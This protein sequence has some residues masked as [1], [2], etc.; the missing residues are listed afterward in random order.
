MLV[1]EGKGQ[2]L[3]PLEHVPAHIRLHPDAY[4]MAVILDK[5]VEA[6]F[7]KVNEKQNDAPDDKEPQ[8]AVGDVIVHHIFGD[9]GVK[10]IAHRHNERADHI[11]GKKPS[12]RFVVTDK[13]P[14]HGHGIQSS[15]Y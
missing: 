15:I 9:H 2:L 4:H 13:V 8:I 3:Q 11:G 1:K 12:V 5:P 7:Y 10:Q 6:R 14:E